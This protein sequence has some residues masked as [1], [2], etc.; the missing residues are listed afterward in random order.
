MGLEV[1]AARGNHGLNRA[2][3]SSV[4]AVCVCRGSAS[5]AGANR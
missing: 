4:G 1:R 2:G 3:H 5:G